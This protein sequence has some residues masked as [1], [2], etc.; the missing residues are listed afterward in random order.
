[1]QKRVTWI[2]MKRRRYFWRGVYVSCGS[3]L[4]VAVVSL[5]QS[6][7]SYRG[8]CGGFFP[9]LAGS[10]ACSFWDYASFDLMLYVVLSVAYWPIVLGMLLLPPLVG[11]VL[12]RRGQAAVDVATVQRPG[13]PPKEY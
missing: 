9:S 3:V 1:M 11:Y 6:T 4:C 10:R 12:D 7:M 2:F 13:G 8:E 5:V